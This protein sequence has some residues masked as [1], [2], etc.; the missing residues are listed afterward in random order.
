[1]D[2]HNLRGAGS[3][4]NVAMRLSRQKGW[5]SPTVGV[6]R[7]HPGMLSSFE[8]NNT[9]LTGLNLYFEPSKVAVTPHVHVCLAFICHNGKS[10]QLA[11]HW[12][13]ILIDSVVCNNA[14]R[15]D[16]IVGVES[17]VLSSMPVSPTADPAIKTAL[18]SQCWG[19]VQGALRTGVQALRT[20]HTA[21]FSAVMSRVSL[22]LNPPSLSLSQQ[23][24]QQR[25][26]EDTARMLEGAFVYGR[27]LMFSAACNSVSNLQVRS[28]VR[29]TLGYGTTLFSSLYYP[30]DYTSVR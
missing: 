25:E 11:D 9:Q 13:H 30:R 28:F 5:H 24:Q 21:R 14:S 10:A 17:E 8:T 27:Y 7:E 26:E 2:C 3:C 1:M 19:K 16:V 6:G 22:T 12:Q 15:I 29:T 20:Q 4:M 18:R 23:Q